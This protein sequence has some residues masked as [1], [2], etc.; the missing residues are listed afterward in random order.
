MQKN[1][2]WQKDDKRKRKFYGSEAAPPPLGASP[3]PAPLRQVMA[4]EVLEYST[5]LQRGYKSPG[6]HLVYWWWD[7]RVNLRV[8]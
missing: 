4:M 5:V 2:N 7:L 6:G 8:I 1:K 3:L